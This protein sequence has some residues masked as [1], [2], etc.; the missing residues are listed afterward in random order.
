MSRVDRIAGLRRFDASRLDLRALATPIAVASPV[1]LIVSAQEFVMSAVALLFVW[2]SWRARDFAWARQGWFAA[3]ATLWAYA[4]LR[5][6]LGA[7]TGAGAS[8]ALHW[9]HFPIYAAAL[10]NWIL[11]DARAR[12][13]LLLAS[14]AALSFFAADCLLQ[15]IFGYD[16]VG[17][18]TYG[19]RLTSVFGKPGVGIEIAWL[20]LPAS[21]GLWQM[22]RKRSAALFAAACLLAVLLTGDRMGLLLALAGALLVGALARELR[23][24]LLI[25]APII[26][27][28]VSG[29]LFLRPALYERQVA[30]T[31]D[32]VENLD[33]SSYGIIFSSALAIVEDHPLF[34][35][36]IHKYQIACLD[37]RYGPPV[38]GLEPRC[39][40]HPHNWYLQW[41]AE[42]GIIGLGLYGAFAALALGA[43]W[44]SAA[45][46]RG[47]LV[48]AGLVAS[49]LLRLWPL[50]AGTGF[51]SSWSVEP[52]FLILGW[53]LAYCRPEAARDDATL[54]A[55]SAHVSH[56]AT[57]GV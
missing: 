57:S 8:T 21:L 12:R 31:M 9:I 2:R 11:P 26:A 15:F 33:Q 44:R 16:I 25:G 22:G 7:P 32:V 30:S 37:E 1:A 38:V 20:Y 53:T 24:P 40:G 36:G 34:G 50:S 6:L 35:V 54:S 52:F 49:L 13:L 56:G 3:L 47:N 45:A 14:V 27:L 18:P 42:T 39:Q 10:A 48:F 28:V 5:T 41:L 4:L 23:K 29:I 19:P 17:R 46:N 43:V 55:P 51:F